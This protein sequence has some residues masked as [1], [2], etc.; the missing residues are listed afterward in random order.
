MSFLS[1]T[2]CQIYQSIQHNNYDGDGGGGDDDQDDGYSD[3]L[4]IYL[5]LKY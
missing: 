2:W 1:I 5:F 4:I 3:H